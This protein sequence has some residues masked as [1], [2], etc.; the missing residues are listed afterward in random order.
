MRQVLR[1]TLPTVAVGMLLAGCSTTTVVGTASP[2]A[3]EP[4]DVSADQFPITGVSDSEVDQFA[5]NALADL[6]TF[7]KQAYPEF[8][9]EE[10]TPLAGGYFSVDSNNIDPSAYPDTGIGCADEYIAPDE[11]AGNA[12]YTS[13]CDLIAY[14]RA[15]IE[16]LSANYGRFLGPVVMAHEFGHAMQ[17]RFGGLDAAQIIDRDAGRLL[18]RRLDPL[19]GRRQRRAR[20]DPRARARRRHPR[21]PAAPRPGRQQPQRPV[22]ARLVLRPRLRLLRRVRR[23]RGLVPRRVRRRPAVHRRVVRP[24]GVRQRGQRSLRGHRR[25]D[26]RHPAGVL[27]DDLPVRRSARTSRHRRSRRSTRLRRSAATWAPRTASSGTASPTRRSTT[28]RRSWPGP[29][30]D[31]I[32]DFAVG[33]AISL[34]YALAARDQAELS[35]NDGDAT[36]SAVC[37]TGWY[38]AQWFNGAF[39][40]AD[41]APRSAPATSTRRSSSCCEYGVEPGGVPERRRVR[42]RAGRRVPQRIPAGRRRLRHRR[43]DVVRGAGPARPRTAARQYSASVS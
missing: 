23:R 34:P 21:L 10:Y 40:G 41:R 11:V 17:G 26:H 1:R 39:T 14:D 35:T 24:G 37:L 31:Q 7:W 12:F 22:G 6:E 16:E 32:G 27:R 19:G 20:R 43:A 5:R 36:R 18:R 42:L 4:S 25:L 13:G 9:G 8:F 28:T 33:T 15:L 3:G 38:T 29:A 2:G 30:Y